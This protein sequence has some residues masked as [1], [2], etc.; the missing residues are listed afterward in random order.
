MHYLSQMVEVLKEIF[1][2]VG[3]LA[4]VPWQGT[5][6]T[7]ILQCGASSQSDLVSPLV[8][9]QSGVSR[10]RDGSP[11]FSICLCLSLGIFLP[12]GSHNAT[13]GLNQEQGSSQRTKE[14]GKMVGDLYFTI[15]S[16]EIV[17]W[18]EIFPYDQ[19]QSECGE[20]I[21]WMWKANSPT[22][23]STF[24]AFTRP[25]TVS[26]SYLSSGLL[27]SGVDLWAVWYFWFLF[28]FVLL[29]WKPIYLFT[30][31][32]ESGKETKD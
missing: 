23:F 32:L 17:S 31:I 4:R 12:P 7:C 15:F 10:A 21:S 20:G 16:V 22:I 13:C 26:F 24:S 14:V 2:S 18:G 3:R 25:W 19:C 11:P 9:L 28:L 29:V 27:L 1:G 30:A 8:K 6:G 5:W